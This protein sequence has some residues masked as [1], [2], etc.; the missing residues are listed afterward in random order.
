LD[1]LEPEDLV[2]F[3]DFYFSYCGTYSEPNH[4]YCQSSVDLKFVVDLVEEGGILS[5]NIVDVVRKLHH[6]GCKEEIVF[7][8]DCGSGMSLSLF[9][10]VQIWN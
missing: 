9:D 10:I 6:Q 3:F 1:E 4:H 7:F 2:L 8:H 5:Q